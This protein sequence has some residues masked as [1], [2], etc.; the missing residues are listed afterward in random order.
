[1]NKSNLVINKLKNLRIN[2]FL[3]FFHLLHP[4]ITILN[5][6]LLLQLVPTTNVQLVNKVHN[7]GQFNLKILRNLIL[8]QNRF[9][10]IKSSTHRYI[11]LF[12]LCSH[13]SNNFNHSKSI[14]T[15]HTIVN[16]I[17][18]FLLFLSHNIKFDFLKL[19]LHAF[20]KPINILRRLI[21]NQKKY[22]IQI[23]RQRLQASF[24]LLFIK[25]RITDLE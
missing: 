13:R 3:L 1:M 15:S 6:K 12:D 18:S 4:I 14:I 8:L 7:G 22:L 10:Y 2:M 25:T 5:Q 21:E 19:L 20:L 16:V 24:A 11:G 23:I 17:E 9:L